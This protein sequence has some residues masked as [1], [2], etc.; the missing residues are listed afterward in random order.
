MRKLIP[1]IWTLAV[2]LPV[3]AA[4]GQTGKIAGVVSDAAT[5]D[6]IPGANV[7]IDGTTQGTVTDDDGYYVILNVRP[8]EY[9]IRASFIGYTPELREDIRVSI[10]LTTEIDFAL[11]EQTVGLDEVVVAA[12]RPVVQRDVSASVANIT[13]QEI[14]NLP[15][16][17]VEKVVG[18]QAGFERGLTVRGEGGDQVQFMVD[19]MS[20]NGGLDNNPFTGV[21]YTAVQEMQVQSGGFNAEYGNVRSGLINVVTKEPDSDR[22]SVDAIVRYSGTSQK[23]FAGVDPFGDD[24]KLP[25]D[26]NSFYMRPM[27]DP[28]VAMTGVGAWEQWLQDEY[29]PWDGWETI[30][31]N[32]NNTNGT[33]FTGEQLQQVFRDHYLRN[34]VSVQAPEYEVDATIGGPVP[35]ISRMLGD[36]R[37]LASY[38]QTQ[39]AYGLGG[40]ARKG[41]E[42]RLGSAKLVSNIAPDMKLSIQGFLSRQAGMNRSES[43]QQELTNGELPTYPWDAGYTSVFTTIGEDGNV[44]RDMGETFTNLTFHNMDIDRSL[45]G[46]Q[47]THTL[48]ATTF[49]EVQ[50]QTQG[51]K[52]NTR[53]IEPRDENATFSYLDGQIMLSEEP[54]GY[55]F[56]D[57]QDQLGVGMI[58]AGHWGSGYDNSKVNR[59][60]GRFDITSQVNR[61]SM[62]K[63]GVEYV[64]ASYDV[65]Y[66]EDDPE[67]PHN[68]DEKWNWERTPQQAAAYVQNKLE[69]RG[70][71]A[72][73]GLRLDYFNAG[74]DWYVYSP[75][76]RAFTASVGVAQLDEALETEPTE[77]KVALSPRLGISFPVTDNSKLYFN[78]GHFRQM[79]NPTALFEVR[80]YFTGAVRG[81][82]N[83]NHPMPK[84]VAYE[85]GFEQNLF[86][87]Y[88]FRI[89]GYYRDLSDQPREV[90]FFSLDDLV[91]YRIDQPWNYSDVRGLELTL[92][93]N[94]GRWIRGFLNYTYTVR[95]TGNFGFSQI[96]ENRTAM[97]DFIT[98][99]TE[100]YT[101]KP[102]PE[103]YAR[104]NIEVLFP[105][106]FGPAVG[107]VHFLGDWRV[108]FL[109]EWRDGATMS[110]DGQNLTPSSQTASNRELQGNVSY[111]DYYMLDMRLSKNFNVGFGDAQFFVDFTNVLNI[112]HMY[113][114]DDAVFRD[115][116][117]DEQRYMRSL[118]LPEDVFPEESGSE[119]PRVFGDD[120]PGDFR[121][122]GVAYHPIIAGPLPTEGQQSHPLYYVPE[123]SQYYQWNGS[124]FVAADQSLVN[125]VLDDK[126]YINMPNRTYST[127]LNPRNVFFGL[128][129][130]F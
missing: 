107:G 123:E 127:F 40:F 122:P 109:G 61:Y 33:S 47:F 26:E 57:R 70:M 27:F 29:R 13:A 52:Y 62:M 59:F 18:L 74:G 42:D 119:Y 76:D 100:H 80:S 94:R 78:Y 45:I 90:T 98:S 53:T 116:T 46:A 85:L 93:R 31:T 101:S 3:T 12:T 35:G 102:V 125:E 75:F 58:T 88:L 30:A 73:V 44:N 110:W 38:R 111:R 48:N 67:H 113:L 91:N 79:L 2:C 129:L 25:S 65:D 87:Q 120:Q 32:Y 89:A 130:S 37:F 49:Y 64:R 50:L 24:V 5:G 97:N 1:L 7:S 115:G 6:P 16:T 22:Y 83:P 41:F 69:F 81:I 71:I 86:D 56:K 36:L 39:N 104:F 21:S 128:R 95:K 11:Q 34:D 72:N 20:M 126:A 92:T 99:T 23:N 84:T 66:G 121:K 54:F 55:T 108:N 51:T 105:Q 118:H 112:R 60:S 103:P 10:D 96:D 9:D 15:I 14:E 63:A 117:S 82:G 124:Q 43:G 106:D 17:D 68:G 8:G 19:G 28:E 114:A 4:W 77:H